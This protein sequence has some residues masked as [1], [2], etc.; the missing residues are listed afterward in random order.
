MLA[1]LIKQSCG[2]IHQAIGGLTHLIKMNAEPTLNQPRFY[3]RGI[4][5]L[6][7]SWNGDLLNSYNLLLS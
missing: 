4:K 7:V 1:T 5:R 2:I 3:L 6:L